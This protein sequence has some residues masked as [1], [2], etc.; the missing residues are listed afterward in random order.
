MVVELMGRHTGWIALFAGITGSADAILIPEIPF[1]IEGVAAHIM[2][3]YS[4]GPRYAIVVV[5]EGAHAEGEDASLISHGKPGESARYG[6]AAERVATELSRRTGFESRT[7]VL[8][9]LQRGGEPT[10]YD[11]LLSLR[12]GSA[13][14][15]FVAK[16]LFGCMV[17]LNPPDVSAVPFEEAVQIKMVPTDR[18][19]VQTARR[20]GISFGD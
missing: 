5:A 14:V 11:R 19:V 1:E 4:R 8:G 2:N 9:H 12:F 20:L 7:L 16:G 13:A 6:G 3:K 15:D 17:G 18:D 10:A